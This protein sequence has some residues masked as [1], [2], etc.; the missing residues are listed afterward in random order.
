MLLGNYHYY[1]I[2]FCEADSASRINPWHWGYVKVS[3]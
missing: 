2:S 3:N 1:M